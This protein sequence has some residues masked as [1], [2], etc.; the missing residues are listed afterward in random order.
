VAGFLGFECKGDL[1]ALFTA[2]S[3]DIG[4][5]IF[6]AHCDCGVSV[7]D[8]EFSWIFLCVLFWCSWSFTCAACG[9]GECSEGYSG[10][11][12]DDS[13]FHIVLSSGWAPGIR[14]AC[15]SRHRLRGTSLAHWLQWLRAA[16]TPRL[17]AVSLGCAFG[18]CALP[19]TAYRT[20]VPL[21]PSPAS[22]SP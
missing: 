5:S 7:L 2:H 4:V 3:C 11:R 19:S 16:E 18:G 1:S 14:A 20:R 17:C 21:P 6:L 13:G 22:C 12:D 9:K 8:G 15:R 10:G